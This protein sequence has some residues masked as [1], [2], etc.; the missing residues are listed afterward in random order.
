MVHIVDAIMGSGKTTASINFMCENKGGRFV[1]ITPFLDE[2]KRIT[3]ECAKKHIRFYEPKQTKECRGS[4]V[5]HTETLIHERKNVA[6][7]HNAFRSYPDSMLDEIK[8]N[9][10]TLIIDESITFVEELNYSRSFMKIMIKTGLVYEE[11]GC[12]KRSPGVDFDFDAGSDINGFMRIVSSRDIVTSYG[13]PFYWILPRELI[14]AFDDVYVLTYMFDGQPIKHFFDMY[15]VPY[16]HIGLDNSGGT[17]RFSDHGKYI[18]EY[19]KD[20]RSHVNICKNYEFSEDYS[21]SSSWFSKHGYY[22]EVEYLKTCIGRFFRNEGGALPKKRLWS[23]YSSA[24]KDLQGSGYAN[25]FLPFNSKSTN[26]YRNRTALAYCVNLYQ[27]VGYKRFCKSRGIEVD[28]DAYALSNMVQWIWRSAIRD[29]KDINVYI[30][31]RR[32]RELLER[33]LDEIT[34][35]ANAAA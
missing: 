23:T 5:V 4:K 9:H 29:G 35:A 7:T 32:M 16:R 1:Y 31:S 33:W 6:T 3:D 13:A 30:P 2:A 27:D 8:N 28:D 19:V 25:Q 17:I 14:T 24:K 21:L 34:A 20:I 15:S 22:R 11:D 18:P 26:E 10:Y 12:I